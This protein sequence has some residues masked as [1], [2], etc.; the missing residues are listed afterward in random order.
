MST[1]ILLLPS[2]SSCSGAAASL[3][4][5]SRDLLS[6][7]HLRRPFLF[8]GRPPLASTLVWGRGRLRRKRKS[9]VGAQPC[10]STGRTALARATSTTLSSLM[11]LDVLLLPPPRRP[12]SPTAAAPLPPH[13]HPSPHGEPS[14]STDLTAMALSV[15]GSLSSPH[16]M[17]QLYVSIVLEDSEVCCN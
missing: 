6:C 2:S 7:G 13:R 9:C 11:F 16:P 8:S 17:L 3:A 4:R 14:I 5:V 12:S 10:S 15:L 1:C